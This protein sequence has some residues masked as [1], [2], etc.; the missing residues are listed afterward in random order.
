MAVTPVLRIV[1]FRPRSVEV[2]NALRHRLI[3][4]LRAQPGVIDVVAGRHGTDALGQRIVTSIWTSEAATDTPQDPEGTLGELAGLLDVDEVRSERLTVR[5]QFR[6]PGLGTA[7]LLRVFRGQVRGGELDLYVGEA[8]AGTQADVAAGHGPI[9]LHLGV[10]APQPDRFVT[11]STWPDWSTIEA[12][13]GGDI[14]QPLATRHPER[15]VASDVTHYE[16][17]DG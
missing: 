1:R 3:P 6:N 12:A 4:A 11:V 16:V 15:L 2:D 14:R 17:I 7:R 5:V 10:V 8:E 13:T 9:T